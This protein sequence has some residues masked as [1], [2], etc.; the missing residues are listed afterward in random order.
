MSNIRICKDIKVY[1]VKSTALLKRILID[2]TQTNDF[3]HCLKEVNLTF[4]LKRSVFEH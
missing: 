2:K 3:S 1:T 4:N